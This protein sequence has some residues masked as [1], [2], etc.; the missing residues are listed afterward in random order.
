[1]TNL[2]TGIKGKGTGMIY[3]TTNGMTGNGKCKLS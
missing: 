3:L 2:K 1:M